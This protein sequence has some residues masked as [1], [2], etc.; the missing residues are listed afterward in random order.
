VAGFVYQGR[1]VD[2]V[3]DTHPDEVEV[4]FE[5]GFYLSN[6]GMNRVVDRF[7]QL[8]DLVDA[9]ECVGVE[10]DR[11]G[12]LAT[13]ERATFEERVAGIGEDTAAVGDQTRGLLSP[14]GWRFQHI[15]GKELVSMP[16]YSA[17]R[18]S[19]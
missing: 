13:S 3:L 5:R 18:S 10:D 11:N 19:H 2:A 1:A 16:A 12:N 14:T 7:E 8:G 9:E 17:A 6:R 15:P 4:A